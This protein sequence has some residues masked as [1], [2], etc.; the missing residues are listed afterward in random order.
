MLLLLACNVKHGFLYLAYQQ[1]GGNE[2]DICRKTEI[3]P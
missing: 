1:I 3:Y 2:N